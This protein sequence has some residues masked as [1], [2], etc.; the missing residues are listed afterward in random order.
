MRLFLRPSETIAHSAIE[1]IKQFTSKRCP[2][3]SERTYHRKDTRNPLSGKVL[4]L[5]H[6][7][8]LAKAL[9]ETALAHA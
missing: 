4:R 2:C 8:I 6:D 1:V 5:D 7:S 3:P 9:K